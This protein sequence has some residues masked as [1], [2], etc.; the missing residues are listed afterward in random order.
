VKENYY[1]VLGVSYNASKEKIKI[2]A[3]EL[4]RKHHADLFKDPVS[5][6]LLEEKMRLILEAKRVLLDDEE[7]KKH[8]WELGI[9]QQY[10]HQ[11]ERAPPPPPPPY[12]SKDARNRPRNVI[13]M[14]I[15]TVIMISVSIFIAFGSTEGNNEE[16]DPPPVPDPEMFGGNQQGEQGNVEQPF[17]SFSPLENPGPITK[18]FIKSRSMPWTLEV[19]FKDS[20]PRYTYDKPVYLTISNPETGLFEEYLVRDKYELT[21]S[22][23]MS[24]N[25]PIDVIP[26]F[27]RFAVCLIAGSSEDCHELQNEIAM[28]VSTTMIHPDDWRTRNP[29][30]R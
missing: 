2:A 4:I 23:V 7:R 19:T 12:P 14:G 29:S 21:S 17:N 9:N 10:Q 18:G 25:I 22:K 20:S 8:D 30:G 16:I 13:K 27:D 28:K 24:F 3:R 6:I 5:K 26:Y 15:I 11:N 1:Q